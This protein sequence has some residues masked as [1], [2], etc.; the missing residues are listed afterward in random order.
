MRHASGPDSIYSNIKAVLDKCIAENRP[1]R[2]YVSGP[3]TIIE[4][5]NITAFRL[6][7]EELRALGYEVLSPLELPTTMRGAE[8]H[9]CLREDIKAICD[10]DMLVLLSGWEHSSGAHL[11]V[12]IAHR[13]G[14]GVI[15]LQDLRNIMFFAPELS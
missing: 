5:N 14:L 1:V 8:W 7:A 12:H 9:D 4:D 11:E 3:M 6:A 2:A 13:L 15:S 10:A